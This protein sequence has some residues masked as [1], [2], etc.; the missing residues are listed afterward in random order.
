[1]H[2]SKYQ[3]E[4]FKC[5]VDRK[6]KEYENYQEFQNIEHDIVHYNDSKHI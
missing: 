1:M 3:Y 6:F 2:I 5:S 4:K